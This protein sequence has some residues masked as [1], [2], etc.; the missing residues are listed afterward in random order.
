MTS[1]SASAP[2]KSFQISSRRTNGSLRPFVTIWTVRYGDDI[3]VR[4]AHGPENGWFV[5]AVASGTGHI[6]AGAV[7]RDVAFERPDSS[8]NT[9]V[10]AAY[11]AK[12]DDTVRASWPPWSVPKQLARRCGSRR[13]EPESP[14]TL[15]ARHGRCLGMAWGTGGSTNQ[16][17]KAPYGAAR[18]RGFR[19]AA[20]GRVTAR[21]DRSISGR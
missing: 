21:N 9:G 20:E 6:R 19:G 12:Y 8:V 10:D 17:D 5:R 14:M 18:S 13:N 3:Y 7:E 1:L 2:P 4:S 11:H 15:G 16:C